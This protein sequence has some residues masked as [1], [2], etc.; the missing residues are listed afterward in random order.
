MSK[1]TT[2][3]G[4]DVHA[5]SVTIRAAE[6]ETGE[7]WGTTLTGNPSAA[8]VA[9][10][11]LALPQPVYCA[12]ES[13]CTGFHLA[14]E[15][16]ALGV[17]CDVIAVSTLPRSQR[18]R[19][20][21]CDRLDAAAI[22][23]EMCNPKR[24]YTTVWVPDEATEAGRNLARACE[25]ASRALRRAR[26]ELTS[27][28]L[29]HGY[30]WDERTKSGGRRKAWTR[31]WWAWANALAFPERADRLAFEHYARAAR[32]AEE[33]VAEMRRVVAGECERP[34]NRPYVDALTRVNGI[35]VSTA[36]LARVEFGDFSRFRSG[37]RVSCWAGVVP[38][39]GSSGER[40]A[41]GPITKGGNKYL[42]RRLVESVGTISCWRRTRKPPRDGAEVSGAVEAMAEAANARLLGR[43][44]HLTGRGKHAN[45]A[46]VAVVS[47]MARWVWAIGL[48]VQSELGAA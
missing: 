41:H 18:D 4:M 35:D 36:Y 22:L 19:R 21:K 45:K 23:R 47:E 5:R 48:Q 13:G 44:R 43:Y 10:W 34:E 29:T 2:L 8:E 40:E 31:A 17:D 25:Q 6:T 46:K 28:L 12:Y 3:A 39:N 27:F 30:V 38:S 7:T 9:G 1:Y 14:R 37:R 20:R 24:D 26:Q 33:E 15:L 16:R 11:L 42:R 32:R